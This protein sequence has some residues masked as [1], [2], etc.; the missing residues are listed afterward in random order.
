[1]TIDDK[2]KL[3]GEEIN[4][5]LIS[6]SPMPKNVLDQDILYIKDLSQHQKYPIAEYCVLLFRKYSDIAQDYKGCS[7]LIAWL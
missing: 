5:S 3:L 1:M 2:L 6:L 7:Y 4:Q